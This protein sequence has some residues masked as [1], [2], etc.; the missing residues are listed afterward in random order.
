MSV[1]S[2]ETAAGPNGERSEL[3]VRD[4]ATGELLG[5]RAATAPEEVDARGGGGRQGAAA[6]GAAAG[7]RTARATCA[8]WPRR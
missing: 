3:L 1:P 6:V 8:A 2:S 4:P 5:Q 7:R